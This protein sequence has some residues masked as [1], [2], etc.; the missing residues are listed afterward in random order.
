MPRRLLAMVRVFALRQ[1]IVE[2]VFMRLV[3]QGSQNGAKHRSGARVDFVQKG[4]FR[5]EFRHFNDG[6]SLCFSYGSAFRGG[7]FRNVS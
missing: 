2:M 3:R 4:R 7:F 6:G 5:V 1:I